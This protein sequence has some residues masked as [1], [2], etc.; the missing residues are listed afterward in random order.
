MPSVQ[1]AHKTYSERDA[2]LVAISIDGGGA[3]T[4]QRYVAKHHFTLPFL[5][6]TDM[7]VARQFGA[8]GVPT[9]FIVDRQGRIVASGYG[10][11]DFDAPSFD[12]YMQ[13]L[14]NAVPN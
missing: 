7:Q 11:I 13:A 1:R 9:T 14:L 8:R 5:V 3:S 4:V 6:D 2:V 12:S 10:P